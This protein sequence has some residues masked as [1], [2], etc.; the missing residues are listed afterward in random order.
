MDKRN[1]LFMGNV[2]DSTK[3]GAVD[4]DLLDSSG[5]RKLSDLITFYARALFGCRSLLGTAE[6]AG[7]RW[8]CCPARRGR[9]WFSKHANAT[10]PTKLKA[11]QKENSNNGLDLNETAFNNRTTCNALKELR[12][13]V[14]PIQNVPLQNIARETLV[15]CEGMSPLLQSKKSKARTKKGN[16]KGSPE[17]DRSSEDFVREL[18]GTEVKVHHSSSDNHSSPLVVGV[19]KRALFTDVEAGKGISDRQ[20][21]QDGVIT[22]DAGDEEVNED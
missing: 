9:P 22:S 14:E 17:R 15:V 1:R 11:E 18:K 21:D 16:Y 8:T 20:L 19:S 4:S 5:G 10:I 13:A 6:D 7:E 2:G 12:N 3:P